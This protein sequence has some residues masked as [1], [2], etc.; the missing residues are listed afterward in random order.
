MY[1]IF[2]MKDETHI[3]VILAIFLLA[4]LWS[5]YQPYNYLT[6]FLEVSPALIAFIIL[7]ATYRAFRLTNMLYWLILLHAI[8]LLIGGHYTYERTPLGY[9][10]DQLFQTGRNNYDKIGHFA[11]GFIPAIAA[12]EIFIRKR[13][14][15]DKR[16]IFLIV[17][18]ICLAASAVYEFIEFGS[19]IALGDD[20]KDFL[21]TQGYRWDT[22]T[23]M[24]LAMVGAALAL[25]LLSK[26][27]DKQIMQ[28]TAKPMRK[29]GKSII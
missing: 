17:V 27:H 23:D 16:W 26:A 24:L 12:R 8:I 13:I 3:K 10:L 9:W 20:A 4:L 6:W 14:V 19:S 2:C 7:I 1:T 15:L 25:L 29:K 21:G 11:Q 22:Q 18:S 5:A 28:V